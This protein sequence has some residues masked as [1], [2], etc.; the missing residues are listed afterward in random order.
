[1]VMVPDQSIKSIVQNFIATSHSFSFLLFLALQ[2]N[3]HPFFSNSLP[4][5]QTLV[6]SKALPTAPWENFPSAALR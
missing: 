2:F 4:K 6:L 1:M 3:S 5:C